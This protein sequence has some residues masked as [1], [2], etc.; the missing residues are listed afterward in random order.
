MASISPRLSRSAAALGAGALVALV[1]AT[2][3]APAAAATSCRAT[4][5]AALT[6][7]DPT[8]LQ[9]DAVAVVRRRGSRAVTDVR[10]TVSRGGRTYASGTVAKASG[11]S[12]PVALRVRRA[13]TKGTYRVRAMGRAAGCGRVAATRSWGMDRPSLPVRAA[14]RGQT[15]EGGG[16][17]V[18]VLLRTVAGRRTRGVRVKLVNGNGRT[19]ASARVGTLRTRT[20]VALRASGTLTAGS[21]RAVVTGR[22]A[23]ASGRGTATQS[24]RLTA[25]SAGAD[26]VTATPSRQR[27]VLDWGGGNSAGR[28]VVGA[29]LPGIGHAEL[30]CRTDAQYL[31]VFPTDLRREVSMMNWTYKDWGGG[32]EK[33]LREALHAPGTGPDFS[34]GLNKFSPPEGTSTGEFLALV[35]DRGTMGA[36][37]PADLA[38]PV[39]VRVT[40]AW[41]FAGGTQS[42]CHVQA[43]VLAATG[44]GVAPAPAAAQVVWR[45]DA[46]AAGHD[47]ASTVVPGVGRLDVVCQAGPTG[48]RTVSLQAPAGTVVTRE[49]STDTAV[50]YGAGPLVTQLP[51]NGQLELRTPAGASV[52]ISSRWKANDPDPAQN[53]C[54]VAA[55]GV[56][57]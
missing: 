52:L 11:G 43:D 28:D 50:T 17:V 57:G 37:A 24:L 5:S 33:A 36:G 12:S 4:L 9:D 20:E 1:A 53:S 40:W 41:S 48:Q 47:A 7:H 34:E 46:S 56:A 38:A 42:R 16:T 23:G 10:V 8:T 31:R 15:T 49:G 27:A 14:L 44:D 19:V 18:R 30:V 6:T 51:N 29:V 35:S 22:V 3:P 21:Y 25:T 26:A 39:A 2:A 32:Q 54:A 13:P 55:L 45:G